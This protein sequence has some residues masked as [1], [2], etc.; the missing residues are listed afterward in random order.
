MPFFW[1]AVTPRDTVGLALGNV[2]VR[3]RLPDSYGIAAAFRT[4][5]AA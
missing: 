5:I 3:Q 4:A 2:A 1:T